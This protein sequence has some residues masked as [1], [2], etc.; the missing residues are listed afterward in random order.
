MKKL[1]PVLMIFGVIVLAGGIFTTLT[2]TKDDQATAP[3]TTMPPNQISTDKRLIIGD[4]NAPVTI[5]EYSDYKCPNCNR[6]HQTTNKEIKA[7]YMD[8]GLVNFEVRITPILG[9]DSGNAARGAY[10]AND[11]NKFVAYNDT[12]Y[13]FMWENYYKDRNYAVEIENLFTT[14]KIIE[15]T[16]ALE[17]NTETFREC[18]DSEKFNQTLDN[19]LLLAAEDEIRGTPGFA[20]GQQTFIG[21]QPYTVFKTLIDIEL[22]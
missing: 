2:S 10:C 15:V 19:N 11:Q 14:D 17:L 8:A 20:I 13:N 3:I 21:A 4:V 7:D 5:V 1:L 12:M 9:P 18:I 16:Q 22:Q 6:F